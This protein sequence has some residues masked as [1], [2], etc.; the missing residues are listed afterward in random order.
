MEIDMKIIKLFEEKQKDV[1]NAKNP[2]LAFFGDSV[3]QGCFEL[4]TDS[5]AQGYNTV[6]RSADAYHARLKEMLSILYPHVPAVF[7]N[8]GISGSNTE[9]ALSRIEEDVLKFKPDLTVVCFGLND[10]CMEKFT[11]EYYKQNL[12]Q[13][14]KMLKDAGSEVIFMTPNMMNTDV[15]HAVKEPVLKKIAEM[16]MRIQTEGRLDEFMEKG[17]EAARE[18][19]VK[20][21]DAY[22]IWKRLSECG[23]NVSDLHANHTNHPTKEMHCIF[24]YELLKTMLED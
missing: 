3:T 24:A 17:R 20:L 6:F 2:V 1:H 22:S 18:S 19:G 16:T 7:V 15:H 4:Y 12:I 13:I 14:F 11:S 21:C 9:G 23:V 10:S 5:S 8:A